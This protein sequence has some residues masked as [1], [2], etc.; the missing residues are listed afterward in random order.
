MLGTIK[1]KVDTYDSKKPH[2]EYILSEEIEEVKKDMSFHLNKKIKI[3]SK[4]IMSRILKGRNVKTYLFNK[5]FPK[6]DEVVNKETYQYRTVEQ[7]NYVKIDFLSEQTF[8]NPRIIDFVN[9]LRHSDKYREV[10]RINMMFY[11]MF[12]EKQWKDVREIVFKEKLKDIKEDSLL[13]NGS[14]YN[15]V[16]RNLQKIYEIIEINEPKIYNLFIE[17]LIEKFIDYSLYQLFKEEQF[18]LVLKQEEYYRLN[19]SLDYIVKNIYSKMKE[20]NKNKELKDEI[21]EDVKPLNFNFVSLDDS[22]FD[23]IKKINSQYTLDEEIISVLDKYYTF[24]HFENVYTKMMSNKQY[25]NMKKNAGSTYLDYRANF[26][27]TRNC[28]SYPLYCKNKEC[29][30]CNVIKELVKREMFYVYNKYLNELNGIE[31]VL[32]KEIISF[33]KEYLKILVDFK[34]NM[35]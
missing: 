15:D 27:S 26:I 7:L 20:Y 16:I 28:L 29:L 17:E 1:L 19:N 30:I 9:R 23:K 32:K 18:S 14:I 3:Q 31:N 21:I 10:Q 6:I 5:D 8:D 34:K 12:S 2:Y 4:D 35:E 22:F 24:K 13:K 11:Y 33:K 25:L